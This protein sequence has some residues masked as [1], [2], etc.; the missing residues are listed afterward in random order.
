MPRKKKYNVKDPFIRQDHMTTEAG[1]NIESG[2]IIKIQGEWGT[3][4]K[5]ISLVTNPKNGAV[6]I[7]CFEIEKG[8]S[9]KYRSFRPERVKAM[10]K[11]R[12]K[13][14][15]RAGSSTAS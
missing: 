6:W 7:D 2:D 8:L 3:K 5:F 1:K 12:G 14:V 13:R 11:K 4:F 15:K 10:P 9:G